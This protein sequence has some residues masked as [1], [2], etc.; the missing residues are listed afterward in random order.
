MPETPHSSILNRTEAEKLIAEHFSA[1]TTLLKQVAN[2]GSNLVLRAY[3]SSSKGLGDAIACGVLLRQIVGMVDAVETL[4]SAG[5]IHAAHLPARAAFEASLYLEWMLASDLEKKAHYYYVSNMRLERHW[6]LRGTQ[7]SVENQAFSTALAQ[8]GTDILSLRPSFTAE[9]KAH[10]TEVNRILSQPEFAKIDQHF[11]QAKMKSKR[12]PKW[13]ALVGAPS[14]RQIAKDMQ[15]LPEYELFYSKGSQVTHTSAY[16]DYL[17]FSK[18]HLTFKSVRRLDGIAAL[19]NFTFTSAF[20]CYDMVLKYYRPAELKSF[21]ALYLS[22]WRE[23]FLSVK[24][25]AYKS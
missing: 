7:G 23:P 21:A 9:S 17:S 11:E 25:V 4:V 12:E 8:L 13:H 2:F 24:D 1:Q 15:Q 18:G 14:V 5:A 3:S 19:V 6:A 22:E 16:K 10:L 20:R